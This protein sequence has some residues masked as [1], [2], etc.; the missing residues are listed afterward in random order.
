MYYTKKKKLTPYLQKGL[1]LAD[2][3][4]KRTQKMNNKFSRNQQRQRKNKNKLGQKRTRKPLL[5]TQ[6]YNGRFPNFAG[7]I[8]KCWCPKQNPLV[9]TMAI[10]A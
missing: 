9:L 8:G 1:P 10:A 5:I 3:P 7:C 6:R 4:P 2:Q